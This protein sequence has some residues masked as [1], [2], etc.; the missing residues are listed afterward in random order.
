MP[1]TPRVIGTGIA[2]PALQAT[3]FGPELASSRHVG[4]NRLR[5]AQADF[6]RMRRPPL[7]LLISPQG[8]RARR[9]AE[10]NS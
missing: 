9:G 8:G 10:T 4:G 3:L 1:D 6:P 5:A 2:G 7:F